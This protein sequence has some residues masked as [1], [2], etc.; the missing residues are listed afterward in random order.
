MYYC[1]CDGE[2]ALCEAYNG[3]FEWVKKWHADHPG[4]EKKS[5]NELIEIY[6]G[7]A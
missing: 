2:E 1:D 6:C 4:E 3:F 7:R 5:M